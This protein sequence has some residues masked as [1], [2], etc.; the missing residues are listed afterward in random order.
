MTTQIRIDRKGHVS[1][2]W[3]GEH[4]RGSLYQIAATENCEAINKLNR[5]QI[6]AVLLAVRICPFPLGAEERVYTKCLKDAPKC[7]TDQVRSIEIGALRKAV[8]EKAGS[9]SNAP[10]DT[11]IHTA[12]KVTQRQHGKEQTELAGELL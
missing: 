6:L 10:T 3:I 2:K 5:I 7:M 9:G 11:Y 8:I 12:V 4:G 1:A